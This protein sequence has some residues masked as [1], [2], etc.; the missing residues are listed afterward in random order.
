MESGGLCF[1]LK[2][3]DAT[4]WRKDTHLYCFKKARTNL[5]VF[6]NNFSNKK[7]EKLQRCS[8]KQSSYKLL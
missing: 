4:N 5:Y 7:P 3:S 2:T 1:C 8:K 6:F